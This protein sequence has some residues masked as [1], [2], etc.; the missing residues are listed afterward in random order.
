DPPATLTISWNDVNNN[1]IVDETEGAS[2]VNETALS[3]KRFDLASQLWLPLTPLVEL[4]TANNFLIVSLSSFSLYA[5][6]VPDNIPP[7]ITISSPTTGDQFIATIKPV[8]I[9]FRVV[10]NVDMHPKVDAILIQ[11]ENR[12]L[13]RGPIEI[14]VTHLLEQLPGGIFST[15]IDPLQID[16]GLWILKVKASDRAKNQ[17]ISES[18]IFEVIHDIQP[19][20]TSL[21]VDAP[22]FVIT[23]ST[24]GTTPSDLGT[25][26][27]NKATKLNL[28]SVDDLVSAGDGLG[29]GTSSQTLNVDLNL[30]FI[31]VNPNPTSGKIFSSSFT[32][33]QDSEGL[34][35]LAFFAQD[36][37]GIK[38]TA[39]TATV[40]LDNT[41]PKTT[42][43][44]IGGRQFNSGNGILFA[45]VD[46][47]YNFQAND[48]I[49]NGVAAGL[50]ITELKIDGDVFR[51]YVTDFMLSEGIRT[52]EFRS[53]DRLENTETSQFFNVRVDVTPPLTT[54]S[55]GTPQVI[56]GPGQLP[57]VGPSTFFGL[58]AQDPINSGVASGVQG[59]FFKT[60]VADSFNVFTASFSIF[61]ETG[62]KA[63]EFFS[64]DNVDNSEVARSSSVFLDA[65]PPAI[66]IASPK[67]SDRFIAT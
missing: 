55:I 33:S 61:G 5:L 19:P 52:I 14:V 23:P 38:E 36:V 37:I 50:Q 65:T 63:I 64:K 43:Q 39:K 60:P 30:R 15:R 28:N 27:V 12:G 46:S 17:T 57:V 13:P 66:T 35:T 62:E 49:V 58:T 18:G 53:K 2:N 6:T 1:G 7:S 11:K 10:D 8:L 40:V 4:N 20:Q 34:H 42:I 9:N 54:L 21:G 59:T 16:D 26:F 47:Q 29:L 45:S 24:L 25:I 22:G 32:I 51:P 67:T 56:R 3:F 48:P 31:F 44:L 41:A